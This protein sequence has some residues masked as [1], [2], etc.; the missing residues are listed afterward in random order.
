MMLIT[1]HVNAHA[2]R[3]LVTQLGPREY[4]V[5]VNAVPEHG[6]A[7]QKVIELLADFLAVPK[8]AIELKSGGASRKKIF[9][10]LK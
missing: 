7:N 3:N 6:K 2:K 5:W 8:S 9:S 4:K 1:V 10:V